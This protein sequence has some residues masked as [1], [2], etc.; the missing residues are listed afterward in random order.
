MDDDA[1]RS[2]YATTKLRFDTYLQSH[3]LPGGCTVL[4]IAN[5]LGQR[6]PVFRGVESPKFMEWLHLQLFAPST[7]DQSPVKLWSDEYRSFIYVEDLA[8]I[9]DALQADLQ[10]EPVTR[11]VNVG[12]MVTSSKC[13]GVTYWC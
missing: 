7:R 13:R 10:L 12:E 9:V 8:A 3:P 5:V 11:L 6:A 1:P 2:V 4:R